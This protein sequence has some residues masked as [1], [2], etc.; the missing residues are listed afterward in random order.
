[1]SLPMEYGFVNE[2]WTNS[3]DV[4]LEKKRGQRKIHM[5][6]IIALVEADWS[7]AL[8][9]PLAALSQVSSHCL[10]QSQM[11]DTLTPT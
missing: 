3:I 2:R 1:M 4:M 11:D 6:Q 9:A 5:L 8:K 10:P 7:T